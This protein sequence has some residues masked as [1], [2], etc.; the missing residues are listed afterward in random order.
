MGFGCWRG[1][2][3]EWIFDWKR[4]DEVDGVECEHGGE[5]LDGFERGG[6]EGLEFDFLFL[7]GDLDRSV[8]GE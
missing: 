4:F 7:V 1:E 8:V 6:L 2:V 5:F 3:D